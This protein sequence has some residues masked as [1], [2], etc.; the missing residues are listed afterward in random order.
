ME[1]CFVSCPFYERLLVP[2]RQKRYTLEQENPP[3]REFCVGQTQYVIKH[4][5][6]KRQ[7]LVINYFK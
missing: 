7:L 5:E 3:A 2:A 1:D 4:L 6:T